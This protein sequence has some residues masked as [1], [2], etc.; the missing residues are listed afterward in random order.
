MVGSGQ[1]SVLESVQKP[2]RDFWEVAVSRLKDDT[3][4]ERI[5][6]HCHGKGIE[7]KDIFL[8]PSKNKGTIS[9][10]VRVDLA[11]KDRALDANNW[12]SGL[13]ISSWLYKPKKGRN[14]AN[15]GEVTTA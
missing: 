14:G 15:Q 5:K 9:A 1:S 3:T 4:V 7:V 6:S 10:K 12:P 11:H 13:R 8:I 2:K